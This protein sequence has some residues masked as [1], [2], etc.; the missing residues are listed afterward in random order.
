MGVC[1]VTMVQMIATEF[2]VKLSEVITRLHPRNEGTVANGVV[3]RRPN[4]R[5]EQDFCVSSAAKSAYA[6]SCSV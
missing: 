1:G 6:K 2:G 5:S 4:E 3:T